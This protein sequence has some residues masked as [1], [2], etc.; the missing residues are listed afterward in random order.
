MGKDRS[1]K[2]FK[3]YIDMMLIP[4]DIYSRVVGYFQ[5]VRNWNNGKKEEFKDR[6][7]LDLNKIKEQKDVGENQS[8]F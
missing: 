4:C 3:K 1:D 2:Y 8:V 7:Y 6:V 5:P